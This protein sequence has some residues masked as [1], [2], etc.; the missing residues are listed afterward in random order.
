MLGELVSVRAVRGWHASQPAQAGVSLVMI[1]FPPG[2]SKAEKAA[3]TAQ[4]RTPRAHE[5]LAADVAALARVGGGVPPN[6]AALVS[7]VH[8]SVSA[9]MPWQQPDGD[10]VLLADPLITQ[11]LRPVADRVAASPTAGS[12][13]R[14]LDLARQRLNLNPGWADAPPV[15]QDVD[16]A[17]GLTGLTAWAQQWRE[18]TE[19]S[20]R[21]AQTD[22]PTDVAA[23]TGGD[24][25]ST[26]QAWV[27][28]E[29]PGPRHAPTTTPPLPGL[30]HP[31]GG[32]EMVWQEDEGGWE[33]TLLVPVAPI[34][35]PRVFE[36]TG[37]SAW[38][39]LVRRFPL[40]VTAS[41]RHDWY[42]HTGRDGAWAI[43]DW[44]AVREE[45][46]AVH[47]TVAGYLAT[48][49][50]AV[51]VGDGVASVLAGWSPDSAAW[52]TDILVESGPRERWRRDSALPGELEYGWRRA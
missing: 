21:R 44:L 8:A 25:W 3:A 2:T 29:A 19:R 5:D 9:N 39:D 45:Y 23:P 27:E 22:R 52:L 13:T 30:D 14:P 16:V 47:V 6:R 34:R 20:E 41:R 10:D 17:R 46:D 33:D 49:G 50:L 32:T 18:S 4:A 31:L 11:S 37:P 28:P 36:V 24:W 12:W 35:P 1:G 15:M 26:P 38:A 48:A 43:P 42:R 7:A 40:E 51:E